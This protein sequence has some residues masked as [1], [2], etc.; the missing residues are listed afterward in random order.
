MNEIE[1]LKEIKEVCSMCSNDEFGRKKE[2]CGKCFH[3]EVIAAL[4]KQVA[5]KVTDADAE[6]SD[7]ESYTC[8]GCGNEI[9][10]VGD[11]TDH[12]YCLLCGQKL[13]WE[14]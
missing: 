10:A 8:P 2:I 13:K 7:S 5:K 14:D 11:M 3:F 1:V 9:Y 4:E 12:K 6:F